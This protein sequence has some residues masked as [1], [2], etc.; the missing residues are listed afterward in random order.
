MKI[1][2]KMKYLA[3]LSIM[4]VS[5]L[6]VG[7]AGAL[8]VQPK[9]SGEPEKMSI[10]EFVDTME[11]PSPVVNVDTSKFKNDDIYSCSLVNQQPADYVVMRPRQSFDMT[12]VV[13]NDGT[14]VWHG[15]QT[16]YAHYSGVPM[17]ANG[18]AYLVPETVGLGGKLRMT[19]DMEAPKNPGTYSTTWALLTG[20]SR[21][22]RMYLIVTV[23]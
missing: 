14:A 18:S 5:L 10:R 4:L 3:L 1:I 12:W 21:I 7:T 2:N 22:C 23:K 15:G 20:N 9:I 11:Y 8:S 6:P 17:Y 19:I 16:S 13:V